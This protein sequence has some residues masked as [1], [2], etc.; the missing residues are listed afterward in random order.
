MLSAALRREVGKNCALLGCYAVCSSNFLPTFR[1]NLSF[2]K[3][4]VPNGTKSCAK[5]SVT[6]YH[7]LGVTTHKG[8]AL[9]NPPTCFS[10]KSPS[11]GGR[12][13]KGIIVLI[14]HQLY[15]YS[16]ENAVYKSRCKYNKMVTVASVMLTY[17][18]L[19]FTD[20]PLHV[21]SY[22]YTDWLTEV[23]IPRPVQ[24]VPCTK[25]LPAQRKDWI[26]IKFMGQSSSWG[27]ASSSAKHKS[28]IGPYNVRPSAG[29]FVGNVM[30]NGGKNCA[31]ILIGFKTVSEIIV[32]LWKLISQLML[33]KCTWQ[34]FLKQ[35]ILVTSLLMSVALMV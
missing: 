21:C 13:Y 5:K 34:S 10:D 33:M 17:W 2:P 9:L 18:W 23:P 11:S 30:N 3:S 15:T 19:Q 35:L 27:A 24:K 22:M 26:R 28:A 12:H 32:S 14:L 4:L 8:A 25:W 20:T 29:T 16:V 31:Y 6:N 7:T 1:D